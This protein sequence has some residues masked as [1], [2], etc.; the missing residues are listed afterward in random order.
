MGWR[1]RVFGC[2]IEQLVCCFRYCTVDA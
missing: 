2:V 1:I